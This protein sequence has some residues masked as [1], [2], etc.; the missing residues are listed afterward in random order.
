MLIVLLASAMTVAM[1]T[2]TGI[3]LY[4]DAQRIH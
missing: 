2:A 4:E 1:L 3:G